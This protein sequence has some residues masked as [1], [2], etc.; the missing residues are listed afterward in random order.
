MALAI[1]GV[2]GF[3][4]RLVLDEARRAGL[5]VRLVGRRREALE[6][7]AAPGEE[8]RVADARDE[9]ALQARSTARR[10][11]VS[12][13]GRSSSSGS[14]RSAGGGRGRA[15]TTSTRA[16][17]RRGSGC[18]TS[19]IEAAT[20][21]SAGVRLRLRPGRPRGA[22]G[23]R[24]G[25]GA[26]R[27]GRR[28]LLG[29]GRRHEPGHAADDRP[30]DGPG[31]GRVGGRPARRRPA[32]A[33]R[34]ARVRFP[35]GERTVVEWGGTEPLTVPRHTDVRNVRSY[36]RAPAVAGQ[37][38]RPRAAGGA[39]RPRSARASAR[40]ARRRRPGARAGSRSS[41]RR[42][43]RGGEGR[44]VVDGSDV[45]GLTAAPARPRRAGA[46]RRR[47]ARDRRARAGGG[48]RRAHARRQA[49][50]VP[51]DRGLM[52]SGP[53]LT[54]RAMQRLRTLSEAECYARCYGWR[55]EDGVR[56]ISAEPRRPRYETPVSGELLRALF[57]DKLDAREPEAA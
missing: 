57:E 25:R 42:A 54:V 32:S 53:A 12:A 9:A 20:G 52:S 17:S 19:E 4:G 33:R 1:L 6:E 18:C 51:H 44:A 28:R 16:A 49:R 2:T 34:R 10:R 30:R 36:L 40:R 21:C 23:R 45:Y 55:S 22:A 47:G 26:A 48:V 38:G 50:A 3:T 29:Q 27:R 11:R 46:H 24:A 35:F 7:L 15:R 43:G 31:A 56:V 14:R 37:G 39:V 41:P 13:P 5:E 8:V